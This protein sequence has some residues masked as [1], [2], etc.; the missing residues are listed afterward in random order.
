MEGRKIGL[1]FYA[2]FNSLGHIAIVNQ[3][4]SNINYNPA[5]HM[6]F[7]EDR[8]IPH[9]FMCDINRNEKHHFFEKS[10]RKMYVEEA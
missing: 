2:A 5:Y 3:F 1:G 9:R 8:C 10:K 6:N 7:N 4:R